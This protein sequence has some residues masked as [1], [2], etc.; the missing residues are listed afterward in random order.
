MSNAVD[1]FRLH[2]VEAALKARRMGP[3]RLRNK[4]RVVARVCH[5]LARAADGGNFPDIDLKSA[6]S[7]GISE[8]V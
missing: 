5:L 1:Y 7:V 6:P 8:Q 3:G 4:Q 2:A